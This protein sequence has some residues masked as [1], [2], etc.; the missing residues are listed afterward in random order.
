MKK[1]GVEKMIWL[2]MVIGIVQWT[3]LIVDV[4]LIHEFIP[5]YRE[6]I[7]SASVFTV[8]GLPLYIYYE[9]WKYKYGY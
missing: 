6:M 4:L 9:Y 8:M 5:I 3:I 1:K 7:I 2:P